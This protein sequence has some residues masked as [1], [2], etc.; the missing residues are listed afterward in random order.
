MTTMDQYLSLTIELAAEHVEWLSARLVELDFPAFEEQACAAG[1]R[2]IIYD[3]SEP[4]LTVARDELK[5]MAQ[6]SGVSRELRF[7]LGRPG[8]DWALAW[9]QHLE[10]VTLTERLTL[11]PQAPPRARGPGELYLKPAFAFGFGEHP[12]TRLAARALE[13][14]CVARQGLS[15][16]D[17]GCGT[18]VLALVA[19]LSG[20]RRV[21][22]ID[23]SEDAVAAARENA[24][25]NAASDVVFLKAALTDVAEQFDWVVANIEG[26][27]LLALADG[28]AQKLNPAG[29]VLLAG[30]ISSQCEGL[31]RRYGEAGVTL[32]LREQAD[33][34]CLLAGRRER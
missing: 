27:V 25:L 24:D 3:L 4:R 32:S 23:V 21:V 14:A 33:D 20:A 29:E 12:S 9:T 11:F 17:V 13:G 19:R 18:G 22:G 2:V 10:P 7:E 31:V 6:A 16:L 1:A 34:W 26:T 5:A 8:G 30:F 15:V 28:I